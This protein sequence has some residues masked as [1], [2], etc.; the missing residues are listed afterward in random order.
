MKVVF[1]GTPAF[2]VE[3]LEKIILAGH[4]VVAVLTQQDKPK[5]RGY[6]LSQ[7]AVKVCAL[8]HGIRVI[9]PKTLRN[10]ETFDLLKQINPEV[11]VVV[12]YGKILPKNIL[13]LPK[14]GC[15]NVHAS[16][17]PKYRGAAP[18]Q[19]SIINGEEKTGV[20]TMYMDEGLDTGDMILKD[21]TSIQGDET[22]KD[23][24][25]RLSIMGAN[26][27]VKTLEEIEKGSAIRI[28][29]DDSLATYA[30]LIDKSMSKIDWSKNA[31]T[32][33]NLVRGL[34]PWPGA[35]TILNDKILKIHKT[36]VVEDVNG[37]MG[38]LK[39]LNPCI[40]CCGDNTAI[41]LLEVQFEGKKR[42]PAVD[43]F[44]G[45]RI[46]AGFSFIN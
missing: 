8:N 21:E 34:N 35:L 23:L 32:I 16:L 20:T 14:Y 40:V 26:L 12:A 44:R 2:A 10:Q 29:Q 19:W 36:K 45:Q 22:S 15:I 38:Q 41:E 24:F 18:I 17:L 33:H 9:Q 25:E 28:K 4:E 11:I 30:C 43:F 6:E 39:S 46:E 3:C 42:M 31:Y 7:S 27:I 37:T 13:S 1:M 5:G